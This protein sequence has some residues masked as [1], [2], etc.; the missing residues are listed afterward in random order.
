M[1]IDA[2]AY[3]D[4]LSE[5]RK[6]L[7]SINMPMETWQA[8]WPFDFNREFA[9]GTAPSAAALK[10]NRFWW[11][12]QNQRL[13]QDWPLRWTAGSP[14]ALANRSRG[15]GRGDEENREFPASVRDAI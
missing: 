5:V 8:V 13:D 1:S 12:K 9:N 6:A 4:W 15:T 10:A 14:A 7:D 3:A 2:G 11:W